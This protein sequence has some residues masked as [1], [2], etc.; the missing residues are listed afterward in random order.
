M[1]VELGYDR[2]IAVRAA[3]HDSAC[4]PKVKRAKLVTDLHAAGKAGIHAALADLGVAPPCSGRCPSTCKATGGSARPM[5]QP[6]R[7]HDSRRP[8]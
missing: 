1:L 5:I 8:P 4:S 3:G 7:P 6:L 2:S